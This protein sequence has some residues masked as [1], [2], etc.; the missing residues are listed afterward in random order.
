[1]VAFKITLFLFSS[2]RKSPYKTKSYLTLS[3]MESKLSQMDFT[4]FIKETRLC[5]K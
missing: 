3:D 5:E 1:M 2:K 4:L